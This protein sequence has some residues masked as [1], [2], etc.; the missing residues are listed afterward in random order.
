MGDEPNL[1]IG[2]LQNNLKNYEEQAKILKVLN[3]K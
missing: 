3:E 1:V 2:S